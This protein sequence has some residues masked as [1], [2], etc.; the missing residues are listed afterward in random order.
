[1]NQSSTVKSL[2][3]LILTMGSSRMGK[4]LGYKPARR[5]HDYDISEWNI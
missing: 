3:S 5:N 1:M 2:I 4:F